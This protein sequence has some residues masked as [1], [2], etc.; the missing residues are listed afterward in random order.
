M[1]I[2]RDSLDNACLNLAQV[3]DSNVQ[4]SVV[5]KDVF[6][7]FDTKLMAKFLKKWRRDEEE[8]DGSH[9]QGIAGIKGAKVLNSIDFFLVQECAKMKAEVMRLRLFGKKMTTTIN[10]L[11]KVFKMQIVEGRMEF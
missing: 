1:N 9:R 3:Y 2:D 8:E 5:G 10:L 11:L 6:D 7:F 4:F